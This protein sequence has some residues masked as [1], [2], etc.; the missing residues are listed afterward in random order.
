MNKEG[1]ALI[2]T[3]EGMGIILLTMLDMA[4]KCNETNALVIDMAAN[5]DEYETVFDTH[6]WARENNKRLRKQN[7]N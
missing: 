1:W 7:G 4:L 2:E 5:P 3:D 6:R